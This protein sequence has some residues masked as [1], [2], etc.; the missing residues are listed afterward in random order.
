MT[1][2][3]NDAY[4]L[5]LLLLLLLLYSSN[6]PRKAYPSNA[7][8]AFSFELICSGN[9]YNFAP[10]GKLGLRVFRKRGETFSQLLL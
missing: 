8:S 4:P 6:W 3:T 7:L 5:L 9:R 2:T 1:M 10:S